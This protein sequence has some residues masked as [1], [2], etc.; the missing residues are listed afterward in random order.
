MQIYLS[1]LTTYLNQFVLNFKLIFIL[2]LQFLNYYN[3]IY[4]IFLNRLS[5]ED[6]QIRIYTRKTEEI[7]HEH[8]RE[9]CGVV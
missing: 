9:V 2:L 6:Y 3:I 1:A 8:E 4:Y 7:E 5:W